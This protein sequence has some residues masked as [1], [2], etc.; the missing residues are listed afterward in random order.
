MFIRND[1]EG[2][3]YNGKLGTVKKMCRDGSIDVTC[4]DGNEV[5]VT[6]VTWENV[7]YALNKDSGE[8]EQNVVG[9]FTQIPLRPAWAITIHKSQGLTFESVIVDAGAAFAFGQVYVALSRCRSIEGLS[10]MTPISSGTLF[11]DEVV[12]GFNASMPSL[13]RAQES[14]DV[15]E[16]KYE[17]DTMRSIFTFDGISKLMWKLTRIWQDN[18]HRLY[19]SQERGLMDRIAKLKE[20]RGVADKFRVQLGRIEGA[21]DMAG[22]KSALLNERLKKASAWFSPVFE[23]MRNWCEELYGLKIDNKET[24]KK[25]KEALDA[26]LCELEIECRC[27]E[28]IQKKGFSTQ[29]VSRIRT[30]CITEGRKAVKRRQTL[31]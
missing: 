9:Q 27:F 24:K 30:A 18:L 5:N 14:L 6:A 7:Q 10:L 19:E 23:E 11:F 4:D 13:S 16:R 28:L 17:F 31:T 2:E 25:V 15:Y 29:E 3:Y 1:S 12:N 20:V 21:G 26:L 8:I 22:D